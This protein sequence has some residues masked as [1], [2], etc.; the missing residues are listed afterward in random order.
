MNKR[1]NVLSLLNEQEV[2][3]YIPAAF[4]LHFHK[5]YHSG[6]PAVDKHLEYYRHT[7]M[8]FVKI[9]YEKMFP[10]IPEIKRPEDWV[11]MPLYKRDFYEGQLGVVKGL[12]KAAKKEALV[13]MT[14][15]SAF[16][17]AEHTVGTQIITRHIKEDPEEVK[18]GLEIITE[19]LMLFVKDCIKLGIDG[20]YASTQGGESHRF[21]DPSLFEA[22]I[23]PHDLAIM[24]EINRSC[25]F[26]VLHICD[27]NGAYSDLTPF[28]D[29]PGQVV[30]Y[31]LTSEC[32][33]PGKEEELFSE[34]ITGKQ[35]S[36]MFH[37]PCMG[38][39]D[40]KGIIVSG[41]KDEIREAVRNVINNA[42]DKFILGA[43]CTLPGNIDWDNIKTAISAAHEYKKDE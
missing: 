25:I 23:K 2:Q 35:V 43:D 20:F 36:E 13:I 32:R 38:G 8:D 21:D 28:L 6:Q 19:S 4:F 26:N 31:S 14:L 24:E 29:Y 30:N 40:R 41:G 10:R 12:V 33:V 15:Y 37:R 1:E 7:G 34:E 16:M 18:K 39:M 27:Y 9:Q 5:D 22:F 42:P 11:K 17:C 3:E